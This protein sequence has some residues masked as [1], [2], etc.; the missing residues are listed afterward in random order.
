MSQDDSTGFKS[1][2]LIPGIG[3]IIAIVAI[4]ATA[5]GGMLF[6]QAALDT[7]SGVP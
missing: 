3:E 5:V 7:M 2:S 1:K 6:F 4:T